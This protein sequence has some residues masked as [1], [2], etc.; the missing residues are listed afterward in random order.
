MKTV[1][2]PNMCTGCMACVNKCYQNAITILDN[3]SSLNAIINKEKCI[4]CGACLKV[5]QKNNP[6]LLIRPIEWYQGWANKT[7]IREKASSGGVASELIRS[8]L[9]SGGSVCSCEFR[10]G[11]FIFEILQNTDEISRFVGSKYVKSNPKDIYVK[12]KNEI[13]QGKKVLFIGL[14]C[15]SVGLQKYISAKNR[16]QLYTIDLICHGT[17]SV[18]LLNKF[19]LENGVDINNVDNISFRNKGVYQVKSG[20]RNIDRNGTCDKYSIAFLNGVSFT[21]NCYSCSYACT[22][23]ASDITL[24][25]SWG[26]DLSLEEQRKGIS[27]ILCQSKK[28]EKLLKM[29]DIHL[30]QVDHIKAIEFNQQLNAPSSCPSFRNYFFSMVDKKGISAAVWK[31]Y[32]ISCLKQLVKGVFIRSGL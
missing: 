31:Y 29:A 26:S 15:Q 12:V 27:L 25:D 7:E 4:N 13:K 20:T 5:C 14:P 17:P 18:K 10:S 28:G 21:E 32:P 1:C 2:D 30:E 8:F 19:F 11:D 22:E 24:G 6:I 23:R 3:C 16:T 9:E